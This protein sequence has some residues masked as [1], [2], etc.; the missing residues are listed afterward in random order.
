VKVNTKKKSAE[1]DKA[2]A[3]KTAVDGPG[4]DNNREGAF[5]GR[6]VRSNINVSVIIADNYNVTYC[7]KEIQWARCNSGLLNSSAGNTILR[8]C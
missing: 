6:T 8:F 2:T 3:M 5:P 7:M 4:V 1:K